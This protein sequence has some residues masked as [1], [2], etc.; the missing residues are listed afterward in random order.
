MTTTEE[1]QKNRT[2]DHC[3]NNRQWD[4]IT[5]DDN[6]KNNNKRL[7]ICLFCKHQRDTIAKYDI[8]TE[9]HNNENNALTV[10]NY[11]YGYTTRTTIRYWVETTKN[12]DRF[13]SQTLNPK[14][15][16]WNKPKKSTYSDVLVLTREKTTGH[17]SQ[18]GTSAAWGNAEKQKL[19]LSFCG[20]E[21]PFNQQQ[22]EKLAVARAVFKTREH[23]TY[24]IVKTQFRHK[25]TGEVVEAVPFSQ[26]GDYEKITDEEREREQLETKKNIN[27]LF[28]YNLQAEGVTK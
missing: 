11:P 21:Y 5:L 26:F 28:N 1:Q 6:N 25:V 13:V 19:F 8:I 3:N 10:P 20:K 17:I 22:L 7:W 4:L 15:Q 12:G 9:Q 24:T 27:R 16:Q 14:K 2:C 23:I 18:Y